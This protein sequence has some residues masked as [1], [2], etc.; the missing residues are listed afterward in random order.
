MSR[1]F[2]LVTTNTFG[3]GYTTNG[4]MP[5]CTICLNIE[6]STEVANIGMPLKNTSAMIAADCEEFSLLPRG[7][8]GEI[9]F[10]GDRGVSLFETGHFNSFLMLY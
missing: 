3:A 6:T 1:A 8:S 4:P 5:V 10:G 7:A 9:C 2:F